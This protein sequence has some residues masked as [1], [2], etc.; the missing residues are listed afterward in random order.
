MNNNSTATNNNSQV[1]SNH[2]SSSSSSSSSTGLQHSLTGSSSPQDD[3]LSI[4]SSN[5]REDLPH[6][7]VCVR[8]I[9]HRVSGICFL[10]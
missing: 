1:T 5:D 4:A 9:S 10:N 3:H 2:G 6:T 7:A 8:N